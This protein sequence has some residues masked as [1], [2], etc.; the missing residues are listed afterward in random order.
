MSEIA[1]TP[2]P[3]YYAVIFTSCQTDNLEGYGDSAKKM[4]ALAKEQPGYLGFEAARS[5]VGIAISYWRDL[6]SI[7]A[8]KA[9]AEHLLAQQAGRELWYSRYTTRICKVERDYSFDGD[10]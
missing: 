1:K 3:P 9:N 2:D 4:E 5:E 6:D 7:K 8:W 10:T